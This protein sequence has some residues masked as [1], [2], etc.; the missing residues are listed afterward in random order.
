M[1][2]R[3]T[4]PEVGGDKVVVAL[5]GTLRK[6]PLVYW[7]HCSMLPRSMVASARRRRR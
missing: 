5:I 3:I 4:S 6:G 1:L 7:A 2:L